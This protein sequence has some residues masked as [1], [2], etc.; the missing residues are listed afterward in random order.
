M[1]G[2]TA[3]RALAHACKH[4]IG[5]HF[6]DSDT[7]DE[8]SCLACKSIAYLEVS[9][10][11]EVKPIRHLRIHARVHMARE[12][13][14]S[15]CMLTTPGLP[16]EMVAAVIDVVVAAVIDLDCRQPQQGIIPAGLG[17]FCVHESL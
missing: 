13:E 17:Y 1:L 12:R 2:H 5:T 11:G 7:F 6:N 8:L 14:T 10:L 16:S 15:T 4:S 3:R 9:L